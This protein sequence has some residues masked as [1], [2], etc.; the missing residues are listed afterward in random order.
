MV[1]TKVLVLRMNRNM[2]K[3]LN[4]LKIKY[5]TKHVS[6]ALRKILYKEL[7]L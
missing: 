4:Y 1:F 7:K 3:N 2:F 6:E 5:K